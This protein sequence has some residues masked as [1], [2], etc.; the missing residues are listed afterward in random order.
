MNAVYCIV[1]GD[2][3]P[4]AAGIQEERRAIQIADECATARPGTVYVVYDRST[5]CTEECVGE[6]CEHE[7]YR[8]VQGGAS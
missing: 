2:G 7:V 4:I 8:A 5:V 1:D 6:E 3:Y